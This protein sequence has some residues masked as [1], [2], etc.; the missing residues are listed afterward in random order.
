MHAA[1]L[2]PKSISNYIGL[3]KLVVASAVDD[4]GKKLFPREWNHRYIDLP[5]IEKQRQPTFSA[6]A[7]SAI[8]Q[9]ASGQEQVLYALLAGSGLRVGEALGLEVKHFS[10][11]RRT[12]TVEQSCWS[13]KIQSPKTENAFRQVDLCSA[14]AELLT[15]FLDGHNGGL[16]FHCS[17]GRAL[18]QTNL[19][20]RSLHPI[21]KE[22]GVEKAGFHSMRRF[23]ATWLRKQRAPEDL[24][25]FWLGHSA[26]KDI[27][28]LYS[29]L[30]EDVEFRQ[31]EAEA[32]GTGFTI[33]TV[34][35]KQSATVVSIKSPRKTQE[36]ESM[37]AEKGKAVAIGGGQ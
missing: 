8:V 16:V 23:R 2:S 32:A 14:L 26:K 37:A 19:A 3:V 7:M 17:T 4:D 22:L 21:L 6:A 5:K 34:I 12:L 20:R 28:D 35:R 11:D 33:P 25:K 29:K 27:T 1:G 18:S 24:I 9:K 15:A 30:K 10:P 31:K 13:G 36:F